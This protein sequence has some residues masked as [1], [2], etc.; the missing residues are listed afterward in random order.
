MS[1]SVGIV[2]PRKSDV[3]DALLPLWEAGVVDVLQ[4][5]V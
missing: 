2:W 4:I 1:P 3:R 5:T